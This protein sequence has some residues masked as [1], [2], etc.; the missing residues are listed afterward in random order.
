MATTLLFA[1]LAGLLSLLSPCVLPILP[2]VLAGA[3]G[4]SRFGPL[5]L[6]AGMA[7]SFAVAGTVLAGAGF[8]AGID[9]AAIRSVAAIA[10]IVFG[11]VLVVPRL[12][13][14]VSAG[15]GRIG[16][17]GGS[18]VAGRRFA[19]A[20]GQFALGAALGLVWSPCVGP[21]LGAASVMASRGE[22]LLQVVVT[23]VAFGVGAAAPLVALGALPRER[24]VALRARLGVAGRTG[25]QI[26]GALMLAAG[27]FVATGIDKRVETLL[28]DA[29]PEWLVDLTTR[30]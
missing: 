25:R 16:E 10:M 17:G 8:A 27:L 11:V 14:M 15:L 29:M 18:L 2:L 30:Y 21:T 12:Q 22:N 6:A 19:G 23:M 26:L 24:I 7:L 3:L 4:E 9:P 20:G 28:V 13:E 5:S 1:T